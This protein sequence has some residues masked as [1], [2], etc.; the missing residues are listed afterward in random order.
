MDMTDETDRPDGRRRRTRIAVAGAALALGLGGLG[1]A[2]TGAFA[3]GGEP[4]GPS[5]GEA[6][7]AFAQDGTT[8][9]E[10]RTPDRGD[11]PGEAPPQGGDGEGSS[12]T[13]S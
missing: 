5:S 6:A 12:T 2:A 3:G 13:G 9:P 8:A 11:C 4:S 10:G 7:T 1:L